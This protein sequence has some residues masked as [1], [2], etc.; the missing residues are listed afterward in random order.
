[1]N[2]HCL[3]DQRK[4]SEI[5]KAVAVAMR[6]Y[7]RCHQRWGAEAVQRAKDLN[8]SQACIERAAEVYRTKR[9]DVIR[10][11]GGPGFYIHVHPAR[12]SEEEKS[13]W[14]TAYFGVKRNWSRHWDG[15]DDED[16]PL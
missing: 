12:I 2:K 5:R 7:R 14:L 9:P 10:C 11:L 6:N 16:D 15:R 1:M 3:I 4:N 8:H 13:K